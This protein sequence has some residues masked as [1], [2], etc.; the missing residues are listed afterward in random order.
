MGDSMLDTVLSQFNHAADQIGLS[1]DYRETMTAFKRVLQTQFPVER[2]DGS[3]DIY[4]GYRVHHNIARGP[5]KGGIRYAPMVSLDEVK[6]LAMLM[7]WKC[8]V[9]NVP[10][11]G[12]KGGVIVDPTQL[13]MHELENSRGASRRSSSRSSAPTQTSRRRTWG[14]TRR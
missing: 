8:A 1:D 13:S 12:A 3:F 10:F 9:V 14:R 2:D 6:A 11:G 5:A 7:T 4:E